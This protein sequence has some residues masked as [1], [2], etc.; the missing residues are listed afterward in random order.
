MTPM[1]KTAPWAPAINEASRRAVMA[2]PDW[3]VGGPPGWAAWV[4]LMHLLSGLTARQLEA[5]FGSPAR[6][7][8][9]IAARTTWWLEQGFA[10]VGWMNQSQTYD[11]HDVGTT[12][13]FGDD[14]AIATICPVFSLLSLGTGSSMLLNRD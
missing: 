3:A 1:A 12:P 8:D 5:E 6:F 7:V 9:W 2:D 11:A 13:G 4:P 14:T 10:P